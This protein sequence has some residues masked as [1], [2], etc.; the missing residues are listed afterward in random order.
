MLTT[1]FKTNIILTSILDFF[2]YCRKK[3]VC[4]STFVRK[5]ILLSRQDVRYSM[6]FSLSDVCLCISRQFRTNSSHTSVKYMLTCRKQPQ[7]NSKYSTSSQKKI[8]FQHADELY[9][10]H[11]HRVQ[12]YFCIICHREYMQYTDSASIIVVLAHL[13]NQCSMCSL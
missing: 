1:I 9:F 13:W 4:L 12:I 8:S 7:L 5:Q 10:T 6:T 11:G 3:R 2:I